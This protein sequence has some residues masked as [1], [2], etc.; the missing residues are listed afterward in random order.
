MLVFALAEIRLFQTLRA[1]PDPAAHARVVRYVAC[2][3]L[4]FCRQ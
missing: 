2:P 4:A 1:Y 3:V